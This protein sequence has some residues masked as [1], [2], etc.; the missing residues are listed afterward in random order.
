M[1]T[2]YY[3]FPTGECLPAK[4]MEKYNSF[5]RAMEVIALNAEDFAKNLIA[6]FKTLASS[7]MLKLEELECIDN[8]FKNQNYIDT[9]INKK[10][11]VPMKMVKKSQTYYKKSNVYRIRN[12]CRKVI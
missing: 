5:N 10:H 12:H 7:I 3:V 6:A 2:D 9:R 8:K 1:G 4:E 11:H